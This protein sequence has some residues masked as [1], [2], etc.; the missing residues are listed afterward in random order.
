MQ[1]Q[2]FTDSTL[3]LAF[4]NNMTLYELVVVVSSLH[5]YTT[6][7]TVVFFEKAKLTVW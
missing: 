7:G 5:T 6:S 1:R 3:S 4:S 2:Y